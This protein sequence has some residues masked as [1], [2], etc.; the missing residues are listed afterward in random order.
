MVLSLALCELLEGVFQVQL[1]RRNDD[2]TGP[3]IVHEEKCFAFFISPFMKDHVARLELK[4]QGRAVH[5]NIPSTEGDDSGLA[6]ALSF[7]SELWQGGQLPVKLR[8]IEVD[9]DL[10]QIGKDP[11]TDDHDRFLLAKILPK[12]FR[13]RFGKLGFRSGELRALK[14]NHRFVFTMVYRMMRLE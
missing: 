10:I 9:R 13:H 8:T 1:G 11:C 12:A 3:D 5:D 14:R 4:I 6:G 2:L 7:A